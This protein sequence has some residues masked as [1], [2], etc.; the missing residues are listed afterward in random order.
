MDD[1]DD[2]AHMVKTGK[3]MMDKLV[4]VFLPPA[5]TLTQVVETRTS[6]LTAPFIRARANK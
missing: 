3:G 2:N 1:D 5:S 4:D 6:F